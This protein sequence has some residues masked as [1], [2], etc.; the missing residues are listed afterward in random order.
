MGRKKFKLISFDLDGTLFKVPA[1]KYLTEKYGCGDMREQYRALYMKGEMSY[2]DY[3]NAVHG[4]L[5]GKSIDEM[6][7]QLD[8]IPKVME[9]EKT[10]SLLK[11][12]GIKVVILSDNPTYISGYLK[13]Y[14][15][16]DVLGSEAKIENG[17]VGKE[18]YV[19]IEKSECL[20]LYC[21]SH[22]IRLDEC[23]H[24]GDWDNDISVFGA[25]GFSVAFNPKNENVAKAAR[26]VVNSD[27]LLDVYEELEGNLDG[28]FLNRLFKILKRYGNG[29]GSHLQGV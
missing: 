18:T 11:E 22:N 5:Y 29:F 7:K 12:N 28:N 15:F 8:E 17:M 16:D 19:A 23:I 9:I 27:N 26:I 1:C 6:H 20:K 24:V 13:R 21:G 25:V 14:G 2:F 3:L 10:V 4:L